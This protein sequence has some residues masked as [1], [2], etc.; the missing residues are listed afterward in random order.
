MTLT[1]KARNPWIMAVAV[2]VSITV[3]GSTA[4]AGG[5]S[6]TWCASYTDDHCHRHYVDVDITR[7][8]GSKADITNVTGATASIFNNLK[9][10]L[11][12]YDSGGYPG[13]YRGSV[14]F[15]IVG[16]AGGCKLRVQQT[17]ER[18]DPGEGWDDINYGA[19]YGHLRANESEAQ[20]DVLAVTGVVVA[21]LGVVGLFGGPVGL[22]T[23]IIAGTLGLGLAVG[24][25]AIHFFS[26]DQC[27]TGDDDDGDCED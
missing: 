27:G 2:A 11:L 9:V 26:V 10:G 5:Y 17:E 8:D 21:V 16:V 1:M 15:D 14:L 18:F 20:E 19:R 25:A 23:G 12:H 22:A 24:V 13:R 4:L 6:K 3:A 7:K